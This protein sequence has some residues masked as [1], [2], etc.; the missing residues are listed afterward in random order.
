MTDDQQNNLE[1]NIDR[2]NLYREESFSDLKTGT[3]KRLTP[4]K[5]DGSE[6]KGRK[7]I[8]VGHTSILTHNGRCRFRITFRPRNCH[9]PLKNFPRLCNRPWNSLSKRS[10]DT[11]NRKKVRFSSRIRASSFPADSQTFHSL[12]IRPKIL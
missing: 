3:I 10:K 7:I 2:T 5:A 11:R 1:F 9:R 6:D 8:F 4:V 12:E